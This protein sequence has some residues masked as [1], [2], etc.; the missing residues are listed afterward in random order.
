[1][2]FGLTEVQSDLR[3]L[4]RKILT[5]EVTPE[6][7]KELEAGPSGKE[8]MDGRLWKE[9]ADANLLGVAL[10]EELGGSGFGLIELCIL[11]EE[12]GRRVAPLPLLATIAMSALPIARF[13]TASQR[14]VL[15]AVVAGD[16]ILTA[17]LQEGAN[18]D[19]LRPA[20]TARPAGDG[21]E[22]HGSKI[23]VPWAVL[24][25]HMLVLA[26]TPTDLGVF[27]VDPRGQGIALLAAEATDRT[28][29]ATVELRG[30]S[31]SRLGGSDAARWTVDVALA[32]LCATA[33]GV[34]DEAVRITARYLSERQQ[35]GRPL[36]TFQGAAIR[37]ADAYI[38][39]QAIRVAAWSAIWRLASDMDAGDALAVA[40]F[41]VADGGQR[42]AH[43][44]QHLHGGMG[45]DVDYPIHRY[46]LWAKELELTLG[47]ATEHLLR[48][49]ESLCT[50]T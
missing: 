21:W 11:L 40:K 46:F 35:F 41:W 19:P 14:S 23:A 30:A 44:C 2:D 5:H 47:G 28:P 22:L 50:S 7:L 27:I 34:F 33:V 48:L 4:A 29:Q 20:T 49:G 37:A 38:D 9:F 25:D 18:R 1:M 10:P 26:S 39:T 16:S 17:A 6:R 15:P 31:A 45:V 36:A 3:D 12:V 42:V 8:R 32:G 24:A 43:A 13:G